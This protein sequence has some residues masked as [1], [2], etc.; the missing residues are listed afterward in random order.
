MINNTIS[1]IFFGLYDTPSYLPYLILSCRILILG[2]SDC[3][4]RPEIGSVLIEY[5]SFLPVAVSVCRTWTQDDPVLVSRPSH[6]TTPDNP[7]NRSCLSLHSR[8]N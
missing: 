4:L 7:E 2:K 6:S 1:R 8:L 5:K 3:G